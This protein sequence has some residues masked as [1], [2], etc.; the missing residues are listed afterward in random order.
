M[1]ERLTVTL[2]KD[3]LESVDKRIDG[4]HI[5]NRSHA[6]ELLLLKSL[7]D[8]APKKALI[9][10]GGKGTRLKPITHEI[11][12]PLILIKGR[13]ILEH[14]LDLL[15]QH[16]VKDI[17]M[18]IGYKKEQIK[19]YFG[20]GSKFGVNIVYVEED[21]SQGTAGA[22]KLAKQYHNDTFIIVNG[23]NLYDLDITDIFTFH[24]QHHAI[25]T[26]ALTSTKD[27]R[28]YGV[29]ELKGNKIVDF[30]EKP[31]NSNSNFINS[32]FYI[33]EPEIIDH[34]PEGFAMLESTVFPKLAK[35]NKLFGYPF[36]GQWF[37][38]SNL[39]EYEKAIKN[40]R[41]IK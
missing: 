18:S 10:A 39:K 23:D 8:N 12:K 11:P 3:I 31:K 24:K 22:I 19:N 16:N 5:K 4:R 21:K 41:G 2:E 20:D 26:M 17:I 13:P 36:S 35:Q 37:D 6:I 1:K 40:W 29:V 33:A 9:L 7:G 38:I 34:I 30:S 15:R 28:E 25:A 14:I 27:T 32:G